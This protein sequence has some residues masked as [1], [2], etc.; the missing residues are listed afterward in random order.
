MRRTPFICLITAAFIAGTAQAAS[1]QAPPVPAN[2]TKD[3]AAPLAQQYNCPPGVDPRK[4]PLLGEDETSG[5]GGTLSEQLSES[6]GIV[7]PPRGIDPGI[8]EPPP[9][10][11][12]LRVIPPPQG[13]VIPK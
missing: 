10:G 13:S 3:K 12:T 5:S 11:G 1:A 7:C 9:A 4:A 8:V 6:R 2:P